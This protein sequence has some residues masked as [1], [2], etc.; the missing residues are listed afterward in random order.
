MHFEEVAVREFSAKE[1][2]DLKAALQAIYVSLN[3]IEPEILEADATPR[4]R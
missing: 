3:S 4:S 1:T 2:S